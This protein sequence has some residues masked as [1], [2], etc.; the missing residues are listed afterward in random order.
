MSSLAM[1]MRDRLRMSRQGEGEVGEFT[2]RVKTTWLC[3]G[4]SLVTLEG[5]NL[6]QCQCDHCPRVTWLSKTY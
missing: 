6:W 4:L 2:P 3:L 1:P 5:L